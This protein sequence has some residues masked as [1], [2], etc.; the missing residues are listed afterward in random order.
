MALNLHVRML[1]SEEGA[2]VQVRA[3][4]LAKLLED[5]DLLRRVRVQWES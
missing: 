5:E 4:N 1:P 3:E 2:I